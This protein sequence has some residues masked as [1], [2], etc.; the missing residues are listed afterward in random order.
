MRPGFGSEYYLYQTLCHNL[1]HCQN[2]AENLKQLRLKHKE[3]PF[4]KQN[5]NKD[6]FYND[7]LLNE[8]NGLF[9]FYAF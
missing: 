6:T 3:R 8:N 4:K 9:Y 7:I 2:G 5:E 1:L